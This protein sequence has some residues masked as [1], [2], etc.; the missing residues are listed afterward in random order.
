MLSGE[1]TNTI[2]LVFGLTRPG[3]EPTIYCTRGDHTNHYT[4]DAVQIIDKERYQHLIKI[5][6]KRKKNP[7]SVEYDNF[8]YYHSY[9]CDDKTNKDA[10]HYH[11]LALNLITLCSFTLVLS[12]MGVLIDSLLFT[13]SGE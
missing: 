4:I 1:A 10:F 2:F 9:T 6:P 11:E 3:L 8:H 12:Y 7:T 13:S 5:Q